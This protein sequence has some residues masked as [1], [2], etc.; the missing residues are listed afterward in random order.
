MVKRS[1]SLRPWL[2]IFSIAAWGVLLLKFWLTNKLNLLIHP[3]YH[4]LTIVAALGLLLVSGLQGRELLRKRRYR[5]GWRHAARSANS[6]HLSAFPPGWSSTIL[7]ATAIAGFSIEPTVFSS[8]T[9]LQRGVNDFL[10][11][12]ES[13]PQA[14]INATPP[15]GRSLIDWVRTLNVYPEPDA[16]AGQKVKV[17]GF[18][19][20]LPTLPAEYLLISRFVITCCAADAYP[21]GLPVKLNSDFSGRPRTDRN[22]YPPDTWWEIEGKMIAETLDGKRQLTIAADSLKPISEP[23]NPYNY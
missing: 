7:L 3:A 2:D 21:V 10:P 1:K 22:D 18:V 14:F 12:T 15:E 19:I 13:Q 17:N 16:Y 4:W 8:Q 23:E 11:V 9:A 6:Q 5:Y 20:H